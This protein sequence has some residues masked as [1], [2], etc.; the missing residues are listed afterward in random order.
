MELRNLRTFHTVAEQL[1]LTKAAEL[2]GYSQPG[3]TLQIKALEKE[4]GRPLFTRVGRQTYLTAAG[5][6]LKHHTDRL[7][8]VLR[9]LDDDFK[10]LDEPSGPLAISTPEFYCTHYMPSIMSSY[11][12]AY[13]DVQLKVISAD[14]A[15]TMKLICSNQADVGIIAGDCDNPEL[16]L[17]LIK[18]EDFVLAGSPELVQGRDYQYILNHYPF[19]KNK[20]LD[21][22]GGNILGE[23]SFNRS[24]MIES[25]SEEAIKQSAIRR[26]GV[27]ALGEDVVAEELQSGQLEVLFRFGKKLRTSLVY[28]KDRGQEAAIQAFV[29]LVQEQWRQARK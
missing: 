8:E 27:C 11:L 21:K 5:K 16:E 24:L 7:F 3:I 25:S 18:V 19:L 14:S 4:I 12:R 9:E 29:A 2:L 15:D 23:I 28:L 1:N 17:V 13:P 26:L 10:K 20:A 6:L 22:L